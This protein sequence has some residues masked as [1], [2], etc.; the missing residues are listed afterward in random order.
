LAILVL[1]C[2]TLLA[3]PASAKTLRMAY[4]ADPTSLDPHEQL[5]GATLQLSHLLFDPL[6]RWR[7]DFSFEPRLAES[8]EKVDARTTRFRL[9]AGVKHQSGNPLTAKDVVWT[10]ERLRKSPDFKALFEPFETARAIDELT[11]EFVAKK[12]YPLTL[13]LATYI[14]PMDSAFYTGEDARGRPKDEI[15][16]HGASFA[17]MN[18]SG[19]GPFIL[20][21]REQGVRLSFKRNPDYWDKGSP[22]NV[23]EIVFTPI[24]EA[25]TRVAALLAGDVDFIAPVPP[26]DFSRLETNGCCD[27]VTMPGT[28]I[29][30]FQ[31]NQE[32][33]A[34]FKDRRVREAMT[35]A[36]NTQAI[37]EK[38]LRGAGTPAGQLS[39]PGYAGHDPEL[40]PRFDPARARKLMEEAGYADGFSVTMMAPN[41]RYVSDFRIAEAVVG[42]LARIGVKVELTTMPKA[43]YWPKFDERAADIMMIGWHS[44][45]EDSAN[46]FEFLAMTP[47]AET[48][49]GQ[50][51]SGNYANPELDRL[52]IESQSVT[53]EAARAAILRKAERI[54]HE[55]AAMLPIHWPHLS[56]AARKGVDIAKVVNVMDFPYLGDLVME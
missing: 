38:L 23:A 43:Q 8:W 7:S 53:D 18:A 4:D 15:V 28:R 52:A 42:M 31:L 3:A 1:V 26:T 6:V 19:T 44:D 2:A 36:I 33:V 55:D 50:Y 37:V 48:G 9:R 21:R 45:T 56:W 16:K 30:V 11:V 41:N 27:L 34:A 12:P 35:L 54:L 49:Y 32:R 25:A 13:N 51:N 29:L 22:G 40:Q 39:P 24:K 47:N 20:T 46:F 17:S 5:A 10:F 14:F